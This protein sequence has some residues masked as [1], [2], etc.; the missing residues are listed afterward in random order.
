M[1]KWVKSSREGAGTRLGL[2]SNPGLTWA[3]IGC[4]STTCSSFDWAVDHVL[5]SGEKVNEYVNVAPAG[6]NPSFRQHKTR[7]LIKP[8]ICLFW[9]QMN[10]FSPVGIRRMWHLNGLFSL[11]HVFVL[12]VMDTGILNLFNI[13]RDFLCLFSPRAFGFLHF[14]VGIQIIPLIGW[15]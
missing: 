12:E 3:S 11:V 15:Y 1:C 6:D 14:N 7:G 5:R 13:S 2:D 9:V 8:L 10:R 4:S